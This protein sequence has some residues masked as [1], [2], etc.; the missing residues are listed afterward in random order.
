M[1]KQ[2][3][4]RE[5]GN[6]EFDAPTLFVL[7]GIPGSG[8]STL[9][10]K[11]YQRLDDVKAP[12]TYAICSADYFWVDYEGKYNFDIAKF[13]D[14]HNYCL[15]AFVN[16]LVL[17]TR[18]IIIDNTN[19]ANSEFEIYVKLAKAY[20]YQVVVI[21]LEGWPS[22][23]GTRNV[24]NVPKEIIYKMYN[25]LQNSPVAKNTPYYFLTET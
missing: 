23:Q 1:N 10:K 24:H 11:M 2:E 18:Y 16:A 9:A 20:D 15:R 14:A 5:L 19:T 12:T 17:A 13:K 3:F 4:L 7:R 6:K 8:K 25:R 21:K 22:L